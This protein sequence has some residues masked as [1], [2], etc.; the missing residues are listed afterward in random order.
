MW[1][2]DLQVPATTSPLT[3]V[4]PARDLEAGDYDMLVR[5]SSATHEEVVGDYWLQDPAGSASRDPLRAGQAPRLSPRRRS[6]LALVA[7]RL[8]ADRID[9][10]ARQFRMLHVERHVAG[11]L[12]ESARQEC[13]VRCCVSFA[14]SVR[15]PRIGNAATLS[16]LS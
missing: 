16:R 3:F 8:E 15:A 5:G 9:G 7:E 6:E 2:S 14:A 11:N 1:H 4:I 12:S 10:A 13:R